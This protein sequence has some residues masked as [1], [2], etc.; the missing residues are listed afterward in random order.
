MF[1]FR[2][3]PAIPAKDILAEFATDAEAA[4]KKYD[5][6]LVTISGELR[7]EA[8]GKQIIY[9]ENPGG[10]AGSRVE[11]EIEDADDIEAFAPGPG[12]YNGFLKRSTPG[13]LRLTKASR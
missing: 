9:F 13:I 4:E 7:R 6:K 12:K 11:C 3:P 2:L 1:P 8:I 10:P 5:K